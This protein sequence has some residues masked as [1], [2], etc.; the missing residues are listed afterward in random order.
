MKLSTTCIA[1]AALVLSSASVLHAQSPDT[2]GDGVSDDMDNCIETPNAD[3]RDTNSDAY[4]NVCDPDL[5]NDL[6]INF[7]DL[8]LMAAVFFSG[9]PDADFDGSGVVNFVDLGVMEEKFF[10]SPGPTGIATYTNA[11][12]PV[13]AEKCQPCHT[14]LR[15][16]GHNMGTTY[17]DALL[18]ANSPACADLLNGEC[19]FVRIQSG[20]MPLGAGC[21]GDPTQDVGNPA[22]LNQAEQ[23]SVQEWIDAGLPR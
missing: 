17:E 2:D 9:E 10:G 1:A 16:G 15:L 23:D 13:F 11:V 8:G 18:P 20:Q 12:Q 4:G 19:S 14:G 21:T 22:C 5:D 6:I 3:Q 7:S